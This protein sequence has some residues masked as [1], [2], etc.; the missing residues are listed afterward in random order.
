MSPAS[1]SHRAVLICIALGVT[2]PA[3]AQHVHG[4]A[5]L[6]IGVEGTTGQATFRASGEDVYGF[7]RAPRTAAERAA[8]DAALVTLRTRG[9][10]LIRFQETRGCA[11]QSDRVRVVPSRDGHDEVEARYRI[12]CRVAP[13]GRPIS[14][15]ASAL[16]KG[17]ETLTVQLVSDTATVSRKI[18]RDRGTVVP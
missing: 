2:T 11:V 8:V 9:S 12:T 3:A 17:I 5:I 1:T 18:V 14:F 16:F 6:D 7:E 15:G 13:A 10:T 4:A